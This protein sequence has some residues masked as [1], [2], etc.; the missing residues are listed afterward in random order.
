MLVDGSSGSNIYP[1]NQLQYVNRELRKETA[2]LEIQYNRVTF[3]TERLT[4]GGRA[5]TLALR[6]AGMCAPN[7]R[8]WLTHVVLEDSAP[9]LRLLSRLI[10][11]T[12]SGTTWERVAYSSS[13]KS[14]PTFEWVSVSPDSA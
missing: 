11:P 1:I 12:G 2:G 9:Y 13:A 6:F 5:T 7:K 3:A 4:R 10:S 8:S 14:F